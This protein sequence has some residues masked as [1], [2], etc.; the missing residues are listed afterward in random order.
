ME[1][2]I[3][4]IKGMHCRSCE[5]LLEEKLQSVPE[6]KEAKADCKTH[7]VEISYEGEL[8]SEKKIKE[9]VKDCGYEVGL[10]GKEGLISKEKNDYIYLLEGALVLFVVYAAAD[11]LGLKD[12][13][14]ANIQN[15]GILVALVVGLV[16]GVST[17]MALVGGLVL[18]VS[19]QFAKAHPYLSAKEKFIPHL[20]FNAGRIIGFGFLGGVLATLGSALPISSGVLGAVTVII[21]LVMIILGINLIGVFPLLKM[22]TIPLPKSVTK[23]VGIKYNKSYSHQ[24]AF[25]AGIMT[26]FL[27]CGFTQAMQ[28]Y[29]VGSGSFLNGALVMSLFALGTAPGLLGIGGLS[30]FAKGKTAKVV[31]AASGLAVI[32]LGWMSVTNGSQLISQVKVQAVQVT[33]QTGGNLTGVQEVKMVQD[34]SGYSPSVMTVK[35]GIKVRWVITSDSPFSCA[36]SIVLPKYGI[37]QKLVEGENIIEFTP[38]ETGNISFS[39][40]MGMYKGKFVVTE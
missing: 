32:F 29:A 31:F 14:A 6:I 22:K 10:G 19:S 21:G 35:K 24:G 27:P 5:L 17:C 30:S 11:L 33:N 37:N 39:C 36:S 18:S 1:K 20:Y 12:I 25:A 13:N 4:P 7:K 15:A 9:V 40:S 16:A 23:F 2:N 28:I 3:I 8:P 34:D 38:T 26:F